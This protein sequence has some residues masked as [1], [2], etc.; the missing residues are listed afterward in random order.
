MRVAV[1][2]LPTSD[3]R[4]W[5][6][7]VAQAAEVVYPSEYDCNW[8]RFACDPAVLSTMI[9]T[10]DALIG[11]A[12]PTREA[13]MAAE[14]LRFLAWLHAGCDPLDLHLLAQRGVQVA[15][16]RGAN[17]VAVAEHAMALLL[18]LA[19]RIR[20]NDTAAREVR[21][22]GWWEAA[23]ASTELFGLSLIHI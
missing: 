16:V 21:W 2:W 19:K 22:Q 1:S 5:I 20:E 9:R 12:P 18:A 14:R 13:I 11:W 3:E 15:N 10:A 23:T 17:S 8:S 7:H 6:E 4:D